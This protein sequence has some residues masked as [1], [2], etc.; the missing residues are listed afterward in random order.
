MKR[1]PVRKTTPRVRDGR[2]AHKQRRSPTPTY[3]NTTQRVPVVDR[4]RPGPGFRHILR[5]QDVLAFLELLPEW[6]VLSQGLDA[7]VLAEGDDGSDGWYD[8]GVIGICA[9]ERQLWR[10]VI[11]EWYQEHK[12]LLERLGVPCERR[13]D[14]V[15]CHF[16]EATIRGYQLVHILVHELGHHHDRITTRSQVECA[17][18]EPYAEA[19][20][21]RHEEEIWQRY[22][23]VFGWD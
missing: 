11:P 4:E 22:G 16:T 20:A 15:L 14:A 18:G 2:V 8:L 23:A 21:A 7:I 10:E 19:Y 12:G 9:W 17:R 5:R 1:N 13:R 6:D 3:W